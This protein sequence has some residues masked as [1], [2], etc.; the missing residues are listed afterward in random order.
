[1]D[2]STA[3]R[4][5]LEATGKLAGLGAGSSGAGAVRI[6]LEIEPK[7]SELQRLLDFAAFA[8]RRAEGQ[9]LT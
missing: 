3:E 8:N 4:L 9:S 6:L 2:R 7:L 5:V 1:M